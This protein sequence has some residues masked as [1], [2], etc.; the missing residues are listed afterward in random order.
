M[1]VWQRRHFEHV[2][3]N[4]ADL[5]RILRSIVQDPTRLL[6]DRENPERQRP[7]GELSGFD[8]SA[9]ASLDD[10]LLAFGSQFRTRRSAI[11]SCI[12]TRR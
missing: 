8:G 12:Y 10:G 4:E 5:N 2:V 7:A 6:L 3:R 9:T 1:A 11:S